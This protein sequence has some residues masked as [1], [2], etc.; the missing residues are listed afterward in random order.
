MNKFFF[1]FAAKILYYC[2]TRDLFLINLWRNQTMPKIIIYISFIFYLIIC[3]PYQANCKWQTF[4]QEKDLISTCLKTPTDNDNYLLA[5]EYEKLMTESKKISNEWDNIYFKLVSRLQKVETLYN[6]HNLL[7]TKIQHINKMIDQFETNIQSVKQFYKNRLS[8]LPTA[9]LLLARIRGDIN[10]QKRSYIDTQLEEASKIYLEK[11]L[12][13]QF[14]TSQSEV[15]NYKVVQN[16]V[17]QVKAGRVESFESDPVRQMTENEF[18]Y[19]LQKYRIYP[20]FINQKPDGRQILD[21]N[22][23]HSFKAYVI[24]DDDYSS[25]PKNF[26][27]K[28]NYNKVNTMIEEVKQYN[29]SQ[30]LQIMNINE[31]FETILNEILQEKQ[32][33]QQEL[34][35]ARYELTTICKNKNRRGLKKDLKEA[36][37]YLNMHVKERELIVVTIKSELSHES[38]SLNNLYSQMVKQAY[39]DL[40]KRA[41]TLTSYKFFVVKGNTLKKAEAKTYYTEPKPIYYNI[42]IRRKTFIPDESG[43]FRCS[44]L[45][46]LKVKFLAKDAGNNHDSNDNKKRIMNYLRSG[47]KNNNIEKNYS[48]KNQIN[49]KIEINRDDSEDFCY[50]NG[51]TP[52]QFQMLTEDITSLFDVD[53]CVYGL[54]VQ[55]ALTH[56]DDSK[57]DN[58]KVCGLN[59]SFVGSIGFMKGIQLSGL[60]TS[61]GSMHGVQIAGLASLSES[62]KGIQIGGFASGS[63]SV[64][65]IQIGGLNNGSESMKGIQIG[66]FN[67]CLKELKGIQI[68]IINYY[69]KSAFPYMPLIRLNF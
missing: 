6:R 23:P 7:T 19:L 36:Q 18:F 58:K 11:R 55:Y 46:G 31:E 28:N 50:K 51:W 30:K 65:G 69:E 5:Q 35:Q 39:E 21:T 10:R 33:A 54:D 68:G 3:S 52:F 32:L 1:V 25:I 26:L 14:I 20:E 57:R 17:V 27:I 38:Q 29:K 44:V 49:K 56:E 24:T 12:I 48:N 59:V 41:T 2:D 40:Y 53:R 47:D 13:P 60:T 63:D 16:T 62:M 9:Y 43:V 8:A 45:L 64:R 34:N 67:T 37:Q 66:A 22:L 4:Y 15:K 42:P 61:I